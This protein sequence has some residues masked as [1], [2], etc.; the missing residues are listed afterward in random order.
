MEEED[1]V[2]RVE[3]LA[4]KYEREFGGCSQCVVGALKEV[5][6]GI[7]DDVFKSATGLAGGIG[8]TGSNACGALTG[9]VMVLSMYK[10][11]EFLNF[12]DPKKSDGRPSDWQKSYRKSLKRN[13][14]VESVKMF[15]NRSWGDPTIYGIR[16]NIAIIW[17][18]EDTTTSAPRFVVRLPD[19]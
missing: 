10:G 18:L 19:G 11:R 17:L 2:E 8:V 15:R 5:I 3:K 9:G 14:A 16:R 7:S 6:G 12:A 1:I 4:T 13:T